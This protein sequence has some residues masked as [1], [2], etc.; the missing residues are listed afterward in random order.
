[1]IKKETQDA[2]KKRM[3]RLGIKEK[4]LL[5]KFILGSGKGGQKMNK[6]HSC[7]YLK[8]LPSKIAVKC[9]KDR[10]RENNRYFARQKLCN[11]VEEKIFKEKSE[12]QKAIE[13]IRRQ[14]QRRTRRQKQK[15]LEDKKKLSQKKQLRYPPTIE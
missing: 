3:Q 10:S 13:K 5:E 11:I 15:M 1:M 2:L 12:K 7:V 8:H 6:T 4:D 9:Q 14:K